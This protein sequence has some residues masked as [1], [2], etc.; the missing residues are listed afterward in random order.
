MYLALAF[1]KGTVPYDSSWEEVMGIAK[2][3]GRHGYDYHNKHRHPTCSHG[4]VGELRCT[5]ASLKGIGI[6]LL[7]W[8]ASENFKRLGFLKEDV[9]P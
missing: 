1:V 6:P 9:Y 8:L 4:H 5:D 7:L 2:R 3:K